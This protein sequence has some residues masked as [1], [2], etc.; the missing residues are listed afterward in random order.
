MFSSVPAIA[1]AERG[2]LPCASDVILA[3]SSTNKKGGSTSLR[4]GPRRSDVEK[5]IK[6]PTSRSS[7]VEGRIDAEQ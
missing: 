6:L 4:R 2:N 7:H 5:K 3:L 1:A